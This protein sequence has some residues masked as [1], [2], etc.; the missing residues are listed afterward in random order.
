MDT[1]QRGVQW[2]GGGSGWQAQVEQ[3]AGHS[4]RQLPLEIRIKIASGY[5]WFPL[6]PPSRNIDAS[7]ASSDA[8]IS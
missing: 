8:R 6:H 4:R 3:Q 7:D 1:R 2:M 5:T